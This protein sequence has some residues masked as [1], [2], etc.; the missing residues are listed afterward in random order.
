MIDKQNGLP[1]RCDYSAEDR[2]FMQ[3]AIELSVENI[4]AIEAVILPSYKRVAYIGVRVQRDC[5]N[6]PMIPRQ[7]DRQR[8]GAAHNGSPCGTLRIRDRSTDPFRYRRSS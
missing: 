5:G 2:E 3:M 8:G 1:E 4:A 6:A 7:K